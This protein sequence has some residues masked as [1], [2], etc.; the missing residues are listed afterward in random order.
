MESAGYLVN[1]SDWPNLVSQNTDVGWQHRSAR[2]SVEISCLSHVPAVELICARGYLQI[3]YASPL[4]HYLC[5]SGEYTWSCSTGQ[6]SV[7][8]SPVMDT[9]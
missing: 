3:L 2:S 9:W 5:F 8:N 1:G 6:Y 7:E 4:M